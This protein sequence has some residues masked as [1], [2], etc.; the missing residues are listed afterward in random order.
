ML[1]VS[2]TFLQMPPT[3]IDI[4]SIEPIMIDG[5]GG[6][7]Y[8][9]SWSVTRDDRRFPSIMNLMMPSGGHENGFP[10]TLKHAV[11]QKERGQDLWIYNSQLTK[12]MLL[13]ISLSEARFLTGTVG[14]PPS[15]G[16]QKVNDLDDLAMTLRLSEGK[17]TR[18]WC[19]KYW[20]SNWKT[21]ARPREKE[22][23]KHVAPC[24]R[25]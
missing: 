16:R 17:G 22:S 1:N 7:M 5:Y 23:T 3:Q 15:R 6:G 24:T 20:S 19:R 10:F 4:A 2:Q 21:A 8:L 9:I 25:I 11:G 14:I 13:I 18:F 12:I